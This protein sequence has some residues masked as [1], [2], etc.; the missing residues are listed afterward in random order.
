MAPYLDAVA[1]YRTGA[2]ERAVATVLR[3]R[4][5]ELRARLEA[6]HALASRA[7]ACSGQAGDIAFRDLEAGP[8][9]LVDAALLAH[10]SGDPVTFDAC[11][12]SGISEFRWLRVQTLRPGG[13]ADQG[14]ATRDF[15]LAL[16]RVLLGRFEPG[17]AAV[18]AE[19]G[20]RAERRDPELLLAVAAAEE[21]HALGLSQFARDWADE[22]RAHQ[23]QALKRL[24]EAIAVAPDLFEAHLRL[25]RLASQTGDSKTA[26]VELEVVA[27]RSP[28]PEQRYLA[29]LFMGAQHEQEG[30]V[31]LA[32]RDYEKS[33]EVLPGAQA[34]KIA[35][36]HVR[37][38]SG[39]ASGAREILVP[40]LR[41]RWPRPRTDD[42][43]W[44]YPYSRWRD[45]DRLLE[46]LRLRV[47][48]R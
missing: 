22:V 26:A 38:T 21:A 27:L 16:S 33:A 8:L 18:A 17:S 36:A 34:A 42:P 43:W 11:L 31:D 23:S 3:W 2:R 35:L 14:I 45:G 15:M 28:D 25:G 7:S 39:D 32:V 1:A 5:A 24:R 44:E 30:R 40:L 6:L 48:E 41:R 4:M 12:E 29:H 37:R 9:L 20:L 10:D 13:C 19:H 46:D 47:S